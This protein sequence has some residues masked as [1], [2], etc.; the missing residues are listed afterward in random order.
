MLGTWSAIVSAGNLG[1]GFGNVGP[2][3]SV[4][5]QFNVVLTPTA[6]GNIQSPP[7]RFGTFDFLP[8]A[9]LGAFVVVPVALMK[10]RERVD[11]KDD[12]DVLIQHGGSAGFT[13]IEGDKQTGKSTVVE[14]IAGRT[15]ECGGNATV[16]TFENSPA[17]VRARMLQLGMDSSGFEEKGDLQIIDCSNVSES[18]NLGFVRSKLLNAFDGKIQRKAVFIDSFDLLY[19]ELEEKEVQDLIAGLAA[20]VK[21]RNAQLYATATP[22]SLPQS[23]LTNLENSAGM[24]L[25]AEKS[26]QIPVSTIILRIKKTPK[27]SILTSEGSL[28]IGKLTGNASRNTEQFRN[29]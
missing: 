12:L 7:Q 26:H 5:L 4:S 28:L 14:L 13:L 8:I 11:K 17:D 10:R 23:A 21:S 16:L 3:T 22:G 6:Y 24:V 19:G 2:I 9:L 27:G 15:V 29:L 1:D 20:E 18:L 25:R